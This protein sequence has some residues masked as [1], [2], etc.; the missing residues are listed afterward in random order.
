MDESAKGGYDIILGRDI[1]TALILNLK[2]S[3]RVIELYDGPLK[4]STSPMIYLGAYQ[5]KI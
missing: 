5:F 3:E 4:V 1:L 2:L